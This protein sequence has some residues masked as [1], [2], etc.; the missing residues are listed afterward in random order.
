[1]AGGDLLLFS[2]F[3]DPLTFEDAA[4][5]P[6]WRDVMDMEI[7][8]IEKNET[9]K[10]TDLPVGN[11][12]IGMKWIYKTKFNENGA[13]NKCKARLVAKGYAQQHGIDYTEVFAP[14]ARWDTI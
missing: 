13:I 4:R 9:W 14:V 7:A 12:R 1:M 2:S 3:A 6:K 11:K 5:S 8:T 10:L